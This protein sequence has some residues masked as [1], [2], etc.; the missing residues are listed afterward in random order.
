MGSGFLKLYSNASPEPATS[1]LNWGLP[2]SSVAVS[3]TVAVDA[4]GRVKVTN[5]PN[6]THI[7]LDVVGFTY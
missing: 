6:A 3:T 1:N 5:G 2:N 7:I 4:L